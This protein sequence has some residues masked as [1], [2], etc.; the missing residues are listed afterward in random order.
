MEEQGK[1]FNASTSASDLCDILKDAM[2][3]ISFSGVTGENI[4]WTAGGVPTD[5]IRVV[6]IQ[7]G[8]Y[9]DL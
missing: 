2:T 8:A 3:K 4:T 6:K 1:S 7:N 9:V 5:R